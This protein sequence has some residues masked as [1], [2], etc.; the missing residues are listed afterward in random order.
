MALAA[1]VD[2]LRQLVVTLFATVRNTVTRPSLM[3]AFVV[4]LEI[5]SDLSDHA[6]LAIS[7]NILCNG[8]HGRDRHRT[9]SR[10]C[11][12][13]GKCSWSRYGANGW[14]GRASSWHGHNTDSLSVSSASRW[15]WDRSSRRGGTSDWG[16]WDGHSADSWS[17][18]SADSWGGY[19]TN[20]WSGYSTNSWGWEVG[21]S[22]SGG[23][24]GRTRDWGVLDEKAVSRASKRSRNKLSRS[25][26]DWC[27]G[28]SNNAATNAR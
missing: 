4:A 9:S 15:D 2:V 3:I 7:D 24:S 27:D 17:G 19:S 5:G 10:D 18:Y 23:T 11:R 21:G 28:S 16:G 26:K 25:D 12:T 14:G 1:F 20:S 6:L 22:L 13:S 8:T